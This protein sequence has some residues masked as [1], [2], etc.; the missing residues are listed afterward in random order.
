MMY[1][2]IGGLCL[3]MLIESIIIKSLIDRV[4][5]LWDFVIENAKYYAKIHELTYKSISNIYEVISND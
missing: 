5:E 1:V 2:L 3:C 4:D